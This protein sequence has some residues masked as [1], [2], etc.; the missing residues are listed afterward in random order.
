MAII[1]QILLVRVGRA[2]D[3]IIHSSGEKT[4]PGPFETV[5]SQSPL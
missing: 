1:D 2:D 3:V 5:V 4:V